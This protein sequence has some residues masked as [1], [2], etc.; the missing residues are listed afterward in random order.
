[1]LKDPF[2]YS[3]QNI[4]NPKHLYFSPIFASHEP[5]ANFL[6]IPYMELNIFFLTKLFH[7]IVNFKKV[8]PQWTTSYTPSYRWILTTQSTSFKTWRNS[9]P[10][11]MTNHYLIPKTSIYF[12]PLFSQ[13]IPMTLF[14]FIFFYVFHHLPLHTL[15]LFIE[16]G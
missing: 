1:M 9:L 15:N 12:S 7:P 5:N 16:H 13:D 8:Q 10:F 4:Q 3:W 14:Y 11:S 6:I 2:K